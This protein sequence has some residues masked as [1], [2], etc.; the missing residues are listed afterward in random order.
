M[1]PSQRLPERFHVDPVDRIHKAQL[2]HDVVTR[3]KHRLASSAWPAQ[4]LPA[5]PWIEQWQSQGRHKAGQDAL[6]AGH[7]QVRLGKHGAGQHLGYPASGLAAG[8]G[9]AA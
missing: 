1:G 2:D 6:I 8:Q 7:K 4:M 3:G 5:S 9:L